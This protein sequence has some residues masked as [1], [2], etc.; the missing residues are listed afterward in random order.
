MKVSLF[1]ISV[2]IY[3]VIEEITAAGT[4][5]K[6]VNISGGEFGSGTGGY[7]SVS[8]CDLLKFSQI[9]YIYRPISIHLTQKWIILR[10]KE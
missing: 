9:N 3:C 1:L 2:L 4:K 10:A 6:G 5:Y 7:G 8:T